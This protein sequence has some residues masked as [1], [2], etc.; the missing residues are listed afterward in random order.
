M[1]FPEESLQSHASSQLSAF[2]RL[3]L[4]QL[5]EAESLPHLLRFTYLQAGKL[6][7]DLHVKLKIPLRSQIRRPELSQHCGGMPQG[8][9]QVVAILQSLQFPS[10]PKPIT[11]AALSV[12]WANSSLCSF[13]KRLESQWSP[14]ECILLLMG[15]VKY[16]LF[17]LVVYLPWLAACDS[18]LA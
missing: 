17:A 6:V 13:S 15:Q 3:L 16:P 1:F 4:V 7:E 9:S 2:H 18:Q 12:C 10:R 5:Q 8:L 11:S 14:S